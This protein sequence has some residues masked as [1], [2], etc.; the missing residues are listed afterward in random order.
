MFSYFII[1]KT[2]SQFILYYCIR[3]FLCYNILYF[4]MQDLIS[5]IKELQRKLSKT[6]R[7]L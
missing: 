5:K 6:G 3:M 2:K 4:Y 1:L 7:F